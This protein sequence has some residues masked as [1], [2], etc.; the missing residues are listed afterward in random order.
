MQASLPERPV[1]LA[2]PVRIPLKLRG[3]GVSAIYV[4]QDDGNKI[5][6]NRQRETDIGNGP[7]KVVAEDEAGKTIE[8]THRFRLATS[9][10]K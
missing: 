5:L 1:E 3:P 7:A 9:T 4:T 6:T 10:W 8:I 2:Q